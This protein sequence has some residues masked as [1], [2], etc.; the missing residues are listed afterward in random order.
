MGEGEA[1]RLAIREIPLRQHDGERRLPV[2]V[3]VD[4]RRDPDTLRPRAVELRQDRRRAPPA[5][6][7]GE[8]HV[9]DLH[10]HPGLPADVQKLVQGRVEAHVLAAHVADVAPPR[11]GGDGSK[12]Q[13]LLVGGVDAGVV[14][15]AGRQTE[16]PRRHVPGQEV[17]HAADLVRGR[18]ALVVRTHDRGAEGPVAGVAR[19]IHAD[20]GSCQRRR[21]L[22]EAAHAAEAVI[23]DH[24]GGHPLGEQ[25][26]HVP[27]GEPVA[28]EVAVGV[29]EARGED[30]AAGVHHL[31][32]RR[33][34]KVADGDHMGPLHPDGG[35]SRGGTR[36]IHQARMDDQRRRRARRRGHEPQG[37]KRD[38]CGEKARCDAGGPAVRCVQHAHVPAQHM[39]PLGTERPV[40]MA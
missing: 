12:L 4:V 40:I 30:E 13:H 7:H 15:E 19:D 16:R 6:D 24:E 33:G 23:A 21:G 5:V 9:G 11:G 14:F 3:G 29:D 32:P 31:L 39:A 10:R 8:L 20:R 34:G 27:R 35:G 38:A 28:V 1:R 37:R 25:R 18:G 2:F 17:P 36:A 26:R 22:G